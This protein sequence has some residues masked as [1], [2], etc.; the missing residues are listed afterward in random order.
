[1]MAKDRNMPVAERPPKPKDKPK[2]PD[3]KK[4]PKDDGCKMVIKVDSKGTINIYNCP[5]GQEGPSKPPPKPSEEC[6]PPPRGTGACIPMS[7]GGKHKSSLQAKLRPLIENS[8]VASVL[9]ATVMQQT[10]R[11][12]R[13]Q[14][15]GNDLEAS[16][17][18]VLD[19]I[20]RASP[21][22]LSCVLDS[23]D[24]LTREE[25]DSIFSPEVL[26]AG[27]QALSEDLIADLFSRELE[28]RVADAVFADDACVD[29]A[30]GLPR[31]V[32]SVINGGNF[33]GFIPSICRVNGLRTIYFQP[34]LGIGG[35]EPEE[36]EQTCTP[37]VVNGEVT[38]N[39]EVQTED[40]PG[41]Q[42][43][44]AE[45]TTLCLRVPEV[46][47]GGTVVLEG[48]NFFNFEATVRLQAK[49]PGSGSAE[50]A[51]FVCGDQETP[52]TE[53]KNGFEVPINDCRV[54]DRL[55]FQVPE[56]LP[57]GIYEARV[58]VPNNTGVPD[59]DPVFTSNEIFI[60]VVPPDT[61]VFQIASETLRAEDETSP[62]WFGS[63][64]VGL[65]FLA[66][67]IFSDL[68]MGSVNEVNFRFGDVD[69]DENRDISRVLIQDDG[70][71]GVSIGIIGFEID[72]ES[73]FE[74]QID[75][76]TEA[77]ID[78]LKRV[79]DAIKDKAKDAVVAIVK[80]FGIKGLIA[81]L[82]AAV[83]IIVIIAIVALWAPAD[84]IIEDTI[85]LSSLD[86]AVLTSAN[87]PAPPEV[88]YTTNGDIDVKV[89]PV[90]KDVQYRE[91]REYHS[92]DE[93]SN[94][95]ITLRYN[96]LA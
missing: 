3:K 76:F 18:E 84:L 58:V 9:A 48:I 51:A 40:C 83:V 71:A 26:S 42:T 85:G 88:E 89:V 24:G 62:A 23:F 35:Y 78:I 56:E 12:Q 64:E 41:H 50:V 55:T 25:R 32:F 43:V 20:S 11:Y 8:P 28:V 60:R 86:L 36:F 93:D 22:F 77:F 91:R 4:Q 90:S 46:N 10:R 66:I 47:A 82:I 53:T 14:S 63:D 61:A 17:F 45:G 39:C 52:A 15:P 67:P 69:S 49:A 19:R 74:E 21:D 34:P 31:P 95:H 87:F 6:P 73:A 75:S 5:P 33:L 72:S 70:L 44:S 38:L 57:V 96:R 16:V 2:Q 68:T 1:M 65:R 37:E 59:T 30:S 13:S 81:V 7:P 79:W 27:D 92:D 80:K 94:Y 54:H 29:E